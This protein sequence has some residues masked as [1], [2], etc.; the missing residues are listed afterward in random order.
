MRNT[1]HHNGR[2]V[3]LVTCSTSLGEG[4]MIIGPFCIASVFRESRLSLSLSACLPTTF[5]GRAE[6]T[7]QSI[8]TYQNS[9]G[10]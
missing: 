5:A 6:G 10:L 9:N 4:I 1:Q 3:A 8:E 7:K 2:R